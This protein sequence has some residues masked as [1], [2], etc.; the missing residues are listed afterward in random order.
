[1]DTDSS[2]HTN[3]GDELADL[4]RALPPAALALAELTDEKAREMAQ[5]FR[6]LADETRLRIVHYLMQKA[7]LNVRTLCDLL[8]QSQ[9]AVSHHLALM[10]VAGMIECRR[11]GKHNFYRLMPKRCAAYLTI[12]SSAAGDGV[13]AVRATETILTYGSDGHA[14]S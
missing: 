4:G 5:V 14:A 6:L 12:V 13:G 8:K 11:D 2:V 7:E 9:P 1:M 10:R 3:D